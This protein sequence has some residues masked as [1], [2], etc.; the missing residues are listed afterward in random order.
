MLDFHFPDIGTTKYD[1]KLNI[2]FFDPAEGEKDP[3][4]RPNPDPSED[5]SYGGVH[6][7][8]CYQYTIASQWWPSMWGYGKDYKQY[9]IPEVFKGKEVY[10]DTCRDEQWKRLKSG[11]KK[12]DRVTSTNILRIDDPDA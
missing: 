3:K 11:E 8:D 6:Y 2:P 5:L 12:C 10:W 9:G 1:R 4:K 7:D